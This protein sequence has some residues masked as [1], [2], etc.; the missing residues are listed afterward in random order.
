MSEFTKG[1]W[2]WSENYCN[3]CYEIYVK[4]RTPFRGKEFL[5][6]AKIGYDFYDQRN[7]NARLIANSPE[8]YEKLLDCIEF[9]EG[10]FG[11]EKPEEC[12]KADKLMCSISDILARIDDKEANHD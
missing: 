1:K 11:C 2:N 8:M 10:Y 12:P 4:N 6:I 9:L 3:A 7:A 5:V